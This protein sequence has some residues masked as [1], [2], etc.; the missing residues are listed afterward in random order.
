MHEQ[1][2]SIDQASQLRYMALN[3]AADPVSDRATVWAITSGKGGVGK[4]VAALSIAMTMAQDG[5]KVLLV[6]A[7]ENLGKLDILLGVH[8]A[9]RL[10]DV[11]AGKTDIED[12]LEH[13]FENLSF[14]G[15]A[16]GTITQAALSSSDREIFLE[17]VHR[18]SLHVSDIIIDTGAGIN[19][20]VLDYTTRADH[21]VV[22]SNPEPTTIVDAYA[23]VKLTSQKNPSAEF[24][25]I[26]NGKGSPVENDD[27]AEKLRIA[28]RHFLDRHI[29][30]AGFVPYDEAVSGSVIQQIPLIRYSNTSPASLCLQ[31]IA[32]RV[33][34]EQSRES[35]HQQHIFA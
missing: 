14:I 27:A 18:S 13:P 8:P 31:A 21:V 7:D 5:R 1:H 32:R 26:M 12:S 25:L 10:S 3:T 20:N 33:M 4:S 34:Q 6:D 9:F 23:V 17:N 15:A 2:D 24:H 16:S 28:I 22:V 19:D 35:H 30:Y 29:S 11:A